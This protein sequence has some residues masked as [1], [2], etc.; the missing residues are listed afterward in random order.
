ME[1]VTVSPDQTGVFDMSL[2]GVPINW[3]EEGAQPSEG[4]GPEVMEPSV[5]AGPSGEETGAEIELEDAWVRPPPMPFIEA[6]WESA[7]I[8]SAVTEG[9]VTEWRRRFG[10]PA[11]VRTF[12]PCPEERPHMAPFGCTA[13]YYRQLLAGLRFPMP[14]ALT[15]LLR[16]WEL[17]V[18]QVHPNA[19]A[20]LTGLYILFSQHG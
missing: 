3:S 8:P 20:R 7:S 16:W 4:V 5:V 17:S 11:G 9:Q 15:R 14:L 6:S 10:I 18:A 13:V 1:E 19:W 12:L 2:E